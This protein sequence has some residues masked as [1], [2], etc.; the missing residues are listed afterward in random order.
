[1]V[2]GKRYTA[3]K[4]IPVA[5]FNMVK[6][7]ES[8]CYEGYEFS[9]ALAVARAMSDLYGLGRVY[10]DGVLVANC[11]DGTCDTLA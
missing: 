2:N 7:V 3:V 8:E 6:S 5:V 9:D 11:E 1:M 10:C 4:V